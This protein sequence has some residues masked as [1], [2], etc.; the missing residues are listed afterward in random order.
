MPRLIAWGVD[1]ALE[2]TKTHAPARSA[3]LD[4]AWAVLRKDVL[5]EARSKSSFNAM[6][7]FAAIV[8]LLFSF[9]L[10]PD[11]SRLRGAAAG[12]M[13][14]AFIFAGLLAFGRAYQ[15]EAENSAFEGLLLV[16]ESRSAIYIGK[17]FGAGLVI[18][19]IEVI[20]I[21]LMAVLYNLDLWSSIPAVFGVAVLG[22]LGFAAI[23]ALYGALTMSL[24][25][26][27]VLLPLL[28]LPVVAPV[29]LGAVKA[30]AIILGSQSGDVRPWIELLVAFDVV[31]ITA[32]ML[33]YEYAA[34]E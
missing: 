26:R 25:A 34:G 14:L 20:I 16:A 10:G 21:P 8:L 13:W 18:L 27:E 31:F 6:L 19:A 3:W 11:P 12:L 24:R 1:R 23:G 29:I 30:T 17:V 5:V 32:G 2:G 28:L 15:L 33:T 7:F 4:Q 22:T 9:A